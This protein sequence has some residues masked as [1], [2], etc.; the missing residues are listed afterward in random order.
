MGFADDISKFVIKAQG[1]SD[2]VVKGIVVEVARRIDMR[3]P[4]GN[5]DLWAK[6]A[7]PGYT[8]GHFRANWQLGV[9]SQPTGEIDGEDKTGSATQAKIIAGIPAKAG[10]HVY[11]IQN[12]LP[13]AQV[14]ED[15][16]TGHS[17]STQAPEGMVG[18]VTVEMGG[19]VNQ[20]A[21]KVNK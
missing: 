19:I 17:G 3:S 7:P 11:Y 1:R 12:N 4:V 6:P 20:E 18:L 15:G 16:W 5:P 10:G 9:D 21:A 2:A 14:L 8:G 13:Y